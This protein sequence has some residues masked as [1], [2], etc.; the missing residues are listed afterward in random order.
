M[1]FAAPKRACALL[2]A[3]LILAL[4]L[5]SPGVE[6]LENHDHR[7][8]PSKCL[9]CTVTH[10]LHMLGSLMAI[11]ALRATLHIILFFFC[12]AALCGISPRFHNT[13]VT[14]KTKILS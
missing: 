3:L 4:P 12:V 9:V 10:A 8:S 5:L 14:L 11:S 2:L 7:C 1:S 6:L 13:P